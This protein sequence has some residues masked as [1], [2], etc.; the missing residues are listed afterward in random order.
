[1]VHVIL[2]RRW[3]LLDDIMYFDINVTNI[4]IFVSQLRVVNNLQYDVPNIHTSQ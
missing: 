2:R 4:K 1:M 3:M